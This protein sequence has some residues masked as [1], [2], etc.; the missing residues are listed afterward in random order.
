MPSATKG[1]LAAT[2][3]ALSVWTARSESTAASG[4]ATRHESQS[5]GCQSGTPINESATTR[6]PCRVTALESRQ[7]SISWRGLKAAGGT[8]TG[9]SFGGPEQLSAVAL[10]IALKRT[11]RLT[12]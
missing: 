10:S 1:R 11:E 4:S 8:G 9:T 7:I 12:A 2:I 5:G 3:Q 6:T